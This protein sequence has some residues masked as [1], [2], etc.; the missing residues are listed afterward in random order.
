M[1]SKGFQC[2]ADRDRD[3]AIEKRY[4]TIGIKSV[5]AAQTLCSKS[6]HAQFGKLPS[7]QPV[8]KPH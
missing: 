4:G 2:K 7:Q 3:A 6:K 8:S 1:K 5:K